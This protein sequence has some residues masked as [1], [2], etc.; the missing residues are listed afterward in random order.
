MSADCIALVCHMLAIAPQRRLYRGQYKVQGLWCTCRG[1]SLKS[2]K[3][4]ILGNIGDYHRPYS[5]GCGSVGY[6]YV[7]ISCC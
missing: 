2:L 5:T 6:I 3:W 4:L 1:H 7:Y